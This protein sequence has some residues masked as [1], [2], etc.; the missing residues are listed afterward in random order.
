MDLEKP[1]GQARIVKASVFISAVGLSAVSACSGPTVPS[2]LSSPGLAPFKS[3]VVSP[4]PATAE[5]SGD[6]D[7]PWL[8]R[9]TVTVRETRGVEIEVL[10]VSVGS[11]S[12]VVFE[13][14]DIVDAAG[15]NRVRPH[16]RLEIPLALAYGTDDGGR[17][18]NTFVVAHCIDDN[19]FVVTGSGNLRVLDE[20]DE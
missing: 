8:V 5:P 15:T 12:E 14:E 3:V 6:P 19:G 2:P 10:Q 4:N 7:T 16:R 9:F 11:Q 1:L 17:G 20:L 13:T 18:I